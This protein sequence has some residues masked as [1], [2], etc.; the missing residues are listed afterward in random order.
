MNVSLT[1]E[2]VS[3]LRVAGQVICQ[4]RRVS[5]WEC[6]AKYQTEG[7]RRQTL[8][9]MDARG[10]MER[11]LDDVSWEMFG[12]GSD[13]KPHFKV[14]AGSPDLIAQIQAAG[15]VPACPACGGRGWVE[16][17]GEGGE[18]GTAPCAACNGTGRPPAGG[19]SACGKDQPKEHK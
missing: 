12:V 6:F 14:V 11:S 2:P 4:L 15:G 3:T 16:T 13:D 17:L 18:P 1:Q 9:V 5:E 10:P 7:S 8:I 19:V